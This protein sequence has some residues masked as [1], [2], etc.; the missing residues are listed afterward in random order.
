MI[1]DHLSVDTLLNYPSVILNSQ[2]NKAA[3]ADRVLSKWNESKIQ[4][5]SP[6]ND[7]LYKLFGGYFICLEV[8]FSLDQADP[9]TFSSPSLYF[10]NMQNTLQ[11]NT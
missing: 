8:F 4:A 2:E 9:Q 5:S 1:T 6:H 10:A 3:L 11:H 7:G